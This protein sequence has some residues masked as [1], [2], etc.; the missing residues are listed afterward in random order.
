MGEVE[1]RRHAGVERLERAEA[2][3]DVNVIGAVPGQI[4]S[5]M[6]KK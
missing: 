6:P 2:V 3:T 5:R 4:V 1:E